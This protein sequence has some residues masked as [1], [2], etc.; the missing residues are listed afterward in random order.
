M[1]QSLIKFIKQFHNFYVRT[2]FIVEYHHVK[3]KYYMT[4]ITTRG[5]EIKTTL[6]CRILEDNSVQLYHIN[7]T[8]IES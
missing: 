4:S 8:R 6:T 7:F 2:T 1:P 3:L 5:T